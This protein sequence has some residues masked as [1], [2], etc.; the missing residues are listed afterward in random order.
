MSAQWMVYAVAVGLVVTLAALAAEQGTRLARRAGRWT[1]ALA[2]VLAVALPWVMADRADAPPST[3][4]NASAL[5]PTLALSGFP[6]TPKLAPQAWLPVG[7]IEAGGT[8]IDIDRLA[9]LAW[10]L[11]SML[12][13]AALI[14]ASVA[15]RRRRR[16]WR[17]GVMAGTPVLVS[18]AAGPAVV[19]VLRP[20][21]V[22]PAWL[23]DAPPARQALVMA[24]E[25]S[26]IAAGDQRLLAALAVLLVV[27]PWNLPLWFQWRRLRL[28]IEVDCDTR[29]M[30]Q[31]HRLADYGAALIDAASQTARAPAA[32]LALMTP[33]VTESAG[34]LERR[35]RLM[36]RRPARWHRVAAPMLLLL[37]LDVGVVAAR[38]GPPQQAG[39][40]QEVTVPQAV[41]QAL[42]GYYQVDDNRVAVVAVTAG[43]LEVKTN[44]EPLWR[45]RA[46][47]PD[48]YFAPATALRLRF[49]RAAG[50]MIASRFGVD[51]AP[52]PRV[53]AAAVAR[54]DAYVAARRASGRP[55][56]GGD[57]IVQRN[58]GAR[59]AS[60]LH[61]ADFTPGFLRLALAQM[62][63]QRK[64]N[65][66]L[67]EVKAVAFAGVD[68]WGWDRYQV[69]Y[70]ARTVTWAI[71]LDDGGRLAAARPE[72]PL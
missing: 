49:D 12:A 71:W 33:A 66:T 41:R 54:A 63:H 26:H 44:I 35:L 64:R 47:A 62:P 18:R 20:Q 65:D 16:I 14:C 6:A 25:Q 8:T 29:V 32:R 60:E 21:I 61:P 5:A 50:T 10:L 4:Q 53:D 30:A 67:G 57:A 7:A 23:L 52:A 40:P 48:R 46:E 37:A 11:S 45:L 17:P 39:T 58:V 27:M 31:G 28:A 24:H 42:A 56:P 43:G 69:R 55:L 15:L 34:F 2:M 1:W 22:V 51:A 19:G 68:R 9:Q 38:I 72:G 70:A 13:L 3:A 36:T 59:A